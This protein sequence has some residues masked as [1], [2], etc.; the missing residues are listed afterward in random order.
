MYNVRTKGYFEQQWTERFYSAAGNV[1]WRS[2]DTPPQIPEQTK[3]QYTITTFHTDNYPDGVQVD[4]QVEAMS[5]AFSWE[6]TPSAV[7]DAGRTMKTVNAFMGN[8]TI[9]ESMLEE[10][11]NQ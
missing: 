4:V 1:T 6:S 8:H 2:C 9:D 5:G 11:Q 3:S 10:P 7:A